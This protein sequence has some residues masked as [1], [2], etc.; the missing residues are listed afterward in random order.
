MTGLGNLPSFAIF[1][2]DG[3]LLW[4]LYHK[5]LCEEAYAFVQNKVIQA[6]HGL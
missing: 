6:D 3:V 5:R 2:P 1:R 4:Y